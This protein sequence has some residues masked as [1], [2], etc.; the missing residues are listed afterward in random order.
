[1]CQ[2]ST[3]WLSQRSTTVDSNK[4]NLKPPPSQDSGLMKCFLEPCPLGGERV[5]SIGGGSPLLNW[6]PLDWL[7][8]GLS[9]PTTIVFRWGGAEV[10]GRAER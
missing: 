10:V 5:R 8:E 9:T 1:M 2:M 3:G 4:K 7:Q 6:M